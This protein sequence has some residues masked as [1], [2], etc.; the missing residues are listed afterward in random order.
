[1]D[2]GLSPIH[3]IQDRT[4][5]GNRFYVLREDLLPF[6]LGGNKVRIAEEFFADMRQ[7][8]CDVMIAYGNVKSN[9]CRVIANRCYRE[10]IPCYIIC[11][12]EEGDDVE[13]TS[14]SRLMQL[15]NASLV[16]CERTKIAET[17]ENLIKTLEEQGHKPYYIYGNKYGAG[18]EGTPARAYAKVFSKIQQY[19]KEQNCTFDYIFHASG[20]GSTQAGLTCGTIVSSCTTPIMG[21]LISSRTYE[22]AWSIIKDGMTSWFEEQKI[23]WKDDY[24]DRIHLLA[25]YTKGGYGKY[26]SQIVDCISQEF[27]VNSLPLDPVYTGKAFLGMLQYLKEQGIRDKNILF[28]HTGGSPLFYDALH[29]GVIDGKEREQR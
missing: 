29:K 24:E 27:A 10:N 13:Q 16:L 25:E 12:M 7:K 26:D 4:G 6:S 22:R 5:T 17:V 14:N 8:G 23:E 20:T 28:I 1:M 19:E 15:L 2:F 18:N 21:V 11:T 9:L 3:P